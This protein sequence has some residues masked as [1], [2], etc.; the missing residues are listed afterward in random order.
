MKHIKSY[1]GFIVESVGSIAPREI[2]DIFL[3]LDDNRI[4]FGDRTSPIQRKKGTAHLVISS[5]QAIAILKAPELTSQ[6]ES[7]P[8]TKKRVALLEELQKQFGTP[9]GSGQV[10]DLFVYGNRKAARSGYNGKPDA[11]D[12]VKYADVP[13]EEA[14]PLILFKFAKRR[15]SVPTYQTG[16]NL[17]IGT[18]SRELIDAILTSK[19]VKLLGHL[20]SNPGLKEEDLI[21]LVKNK[22]VD[23]AIAAVRNLG[24]TPRVL[25]IAAKRPNTPVRF[26]AASNELTPKE[27]LADLF[28]N[29]TDHGVLLA[30]LSNKN[31]PVDEINR[32]SKSSSRAEEIIA[33]VKNPNLSKENAE[34]LLAQ[35]AK[36]T[37]EYYRELAAE[38]PRTSIDVLDELSKSISSKVAEK[39]KQNLKGRDFS[40]WVFKDTWE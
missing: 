7:D 22:N 13:Q 33:L 18:L 39:A 23:V 24:V 20:A 3:I 4:E 14:A 9:G 21:A 30:V 10:S 16:R 2:H 5:N 8:T 28:S 17:T 36:S 29:E 26:A 31:S 32:Y 1:L 25:S 35:L 6:L 11:S 15:L 27:V 12:M 40:D 19:D 38:N 37:Y 34:R